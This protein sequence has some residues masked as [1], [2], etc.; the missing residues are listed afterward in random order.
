VAAGRNKA[1]AQPH[2]HG[3]PGGRHEHSFRTTC[4]TLQKCFIISEITSCTASNNYQCIQSVTSLLILGIWLD[5]SCILGSSPCFTQ[6]K[7]YHLAE[8]SCTRRGKIRLRCSPH[9]DAN[10]LSSFQDIQLR[11]SYRFIIADGYFR[12]VRRPAGWLLLQRFW[13]RSQK[14]KRGRH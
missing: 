11:V 1:L 7:R 2:Q 6:F 4:G 9:R 8:D 14:C 3:T 10:A 13:R 12:T 5:R